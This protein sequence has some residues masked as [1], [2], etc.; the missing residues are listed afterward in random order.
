MRNDDHWSLEEQLAGEQNPTQFGHMLA[1]LAIGYV[2]AHSP[3]AKGRIERLWETLQDRLV[4]E[5]RL[6]GIDTIEAAA[7]FLPEF[8]RDYNQRFARPARDT[9][10]AWRR[11]PRTFE[12]I[13]SC[14]YARVVANDNT[15]TL[16]GRWIQ[17]PPRGRGRSWQGCRVEARELIDGRLFVL[18][19]DQLIAEQ[20]WPLSTPFTLV[21][22]NS[23]PKRRAALGIDLPESSRID[24]RLAVKVRTRPRKKGI[25]Q[26]TNIRRPKPQHPWNQ[27]ANPKPPP[28]KTAG[29]G[30]T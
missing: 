28:A 7:A 3:Q 18:H 19:R 10:A 26:Y 17:L 5:L 16:P 23:D 21:P 14:R 6:R 13:L 9:A 4:A 11:A 25:G 30:G 2:T 12:P 27:S 1:E 20:P 29:A 22:R 24:D 15:I 8:I